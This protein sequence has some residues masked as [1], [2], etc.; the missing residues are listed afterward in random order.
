MLKLAIQVMSNRHLRQ[1]KRKELRSGKRCEHDLIGDI[2]IHNL[3]K[4]QKRGMRRYHK[5]KIFLAVFSVCLLFG[6]VCFVF[7]FGPQV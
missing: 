7:W 1:K 5:D 4:G 6:F 3:D 2:K